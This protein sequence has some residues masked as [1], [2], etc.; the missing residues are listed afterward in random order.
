MRPQIAP[1]G[2][3]GKPG[4]ICNPA[5]PLFVYKPV[6]CQCESVWSEIC[7]R[8][9]DSKCKRVTNI[10]RVSRILLG[11]KVS[12]GTG[13]DIPTDIPCPTSRARHPASRSS[14][15]PQARIQETLS[16]KQ[17]ITQVWNDFIVIRKKGSTSCYRANWYVAPAT[18]ELLLIKTSVRCTTIYGDRCA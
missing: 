7:S 3:R 12:H 8:L 18:E 5:R 15:R 13:T 10:S 9:L 17:N 6:N 14:H 2:K 16:W 4:P 11:T 1:F